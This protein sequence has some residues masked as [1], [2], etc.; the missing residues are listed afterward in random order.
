MHTEM[1]AVYSYRQCICIGF[2]RGC[3]AF[4]MPAADISSLSLTGAGMLQ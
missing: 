2:N 4:T 1:S 3:L